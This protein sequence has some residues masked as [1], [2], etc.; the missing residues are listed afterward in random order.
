MRSGQFYDELQHLCKIVY[1]CPKQN[2]KQ[3]VYQEQACCKDGLFVAIYTNNEN[4]AF[5]IRGTEDI[6]DVKTDLNMWLHKFNSQFSSAFIYY[7]KIR[8]KYKNIIF[9]GHSLGGSIAQYLGTTCGNETITFQAYGIANNYDKKHVNNIINFGN[10]YDPVFISNF[11]NHVG[12]NYIMP[13]QASNISFKYHFLDTCG[14][15]SQAKQIDFDPSSNFYTDM[16]KPLV[17]Y[18]A[19]NVKDFVKQQINNH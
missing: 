18:A 12:N 3:W 13:I 10:L 5:V 4:T 19:Q 17:K 7:I 14:H 9:T 15:A 1:D 2:Y 16:A 8:N 11:K 6:Q